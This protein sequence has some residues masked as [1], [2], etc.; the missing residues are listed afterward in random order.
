MTDECDRPEGRMECL[1]VNTWAL[2]DIV[3]PP[4]RPLLQPLPP[5][6]SLTDTNRLFTRASGCHSLY[7]IITSLRHSLPT[8]SHGMPTMPAVNTP[9]PAVSHLNSATHFVSD[10]LSTQKK[11]YVSRIQTWLVVTSGSEGLN[12]KRRMVVSWLC[13]SRCS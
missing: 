4:L 7:G 1:T 8:L 11:D 5:E 10:Y 2:A 12:P 3:A 6:A 9:L 13:E